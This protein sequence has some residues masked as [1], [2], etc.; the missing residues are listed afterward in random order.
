MCTKEYALK[1]K[2]AKAETNLLLTTSFRFVVL[3]NNH[4]KFPVFET[5]T[6]TIYHH[7]DPCHSD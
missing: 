3:V 5:T 2:K 7:F 1:T 4:M 6:V